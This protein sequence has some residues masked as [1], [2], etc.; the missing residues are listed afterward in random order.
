L[1]IRQKEWGGGRVKPE[2]E[3]PGHSAA[4]P[5]PKKRKAE[6]YRE[7]RK[8]AKAINFSQKL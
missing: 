3:P 1:T 6:F 8:K 4:G 2:I 5:P 7:T